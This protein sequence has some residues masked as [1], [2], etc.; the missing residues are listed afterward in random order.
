MLILALFCTDYL[1]NQTKQNRP[2]TGGF[3]LGRSLVLAQNV[4]F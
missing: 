3:V 4:N 1:V 2:K